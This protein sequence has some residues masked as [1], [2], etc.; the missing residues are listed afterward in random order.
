MSEEKQSHTSED[1][2][3][4][5]LELQN[6]LKATELKAIGL[7]NENQQYKMNIAPDAMRMKAELNIELEVAQTFITSGAFPNVTKEQAYVIMKAGQE[8]GLDKVESLQSLYITPKGKIEI[9]GKAL[10]GFIKRGGYEIEYQEEIESSVVVRVFHP[11]N[12]YDYRE[13]VTDQDQVIKAKYRKDGSKRT[14]AIDFA[15]KNKMRFHGLRM[16]LN[17]RLAHLIKATSDL[18]SNDFLEWKEQQQLDSKIQLGLPV[19]SQPGLDL[20]AIEANKNIERIS[21]RLKTAT[22]LQ[23]V[24]LRE[25]CEK[26]NL[27]DLYEDRVDELEALEAEQRQNS[28]EG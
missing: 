5:I 3:K 14:S 7:Y 13:L 9:F 6:K 23:L 16:H 20:E 1:L 21:N 26:L 28:N 8:M 25:T 27:M 19:E 22:G 12:G 17:F 24:N 18:F 2:L 10:T 15:K 4:Q 11:T